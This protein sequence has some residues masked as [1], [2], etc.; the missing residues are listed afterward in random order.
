MGRDGNGSSNA[1]RGDVLRVLGVLKIAT[2]AQIYRLERPHLA[3]RHTDKKPADQGSAR[4][5]ATRNAAGDLIREGLVVAAGST[6]GRGETLFSLTSRGLEAAAAELDRPGWEMGGTASNAG[7]SGAPHAMSV[8]ETVLALIRPKPDLGMLTGEPANALAAA[9]AAVAAP[10]GIGTIGS[11]A[12]E[13]P[14][15]LTG[16]WT[17]PGRG[18]G[19]VQADIV[20][21]APENGIP[22]LFIEVDNG[23]ETAQKIAAK[24]PKYQR[25]FQKTLKDP[26]GKSTGTPLWH[27]RWPHPVDDPYGAEPHPA[28]LLVFTQRGARNARNV[29][30]TVEQ[31]TCPQWKGTWEPEAREFHTYEGKIPIVATTLDLL[32]QHGP[33]G[34]VFRRFGRSHDQD[35]AGAIGN[36]RQTAV[37]ARRRAE[38]ERRTVR[39]KQERE[40]RRPVCADCG[41]VFTDAQ[42]QTADPSGWS[43]DPR[44]SNRTNGWSG[45]DSQP[46]PLPV[47]CD[48]CDREARDRAQHKAMEEAAARR[49]RAAEEEER[50][51]EEAA[52]AAR[53]ARRF[54]FPFRS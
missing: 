7:R 45:E 6:V 28:V 26:G 40:A 34:E 46:S 33:A 41:T 21:T 39:A 19:G 30:R 12:T 53:K 42:W 38:D 22:L 47:R 37:L 15:P 1:E 11:Y 51:M 16:T 3:Y 25:F 27:T 4:N 24:F 23:H 35:L 32:R 36:P 9:E 17:A 49:A 8:N 20:L 10:D 5:K 18:A 43:L 29:V 2:A 50:Q 13:V 52:A 14:L 44:W 48:H 31:L 54:P